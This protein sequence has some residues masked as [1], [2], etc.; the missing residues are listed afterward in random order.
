LANDISDLSGSKPKCRILRITIY[1][2]GRSG[3]LP[4]TESDRDVR[5]GEEQPSKT[6]KRDRRHATC[7]IADETRDFRA[8]RLVT[9][10]H[11]T[12]QPM[13]IREKIGI[14]RCLCQ[15]QSVEQWAYPKLST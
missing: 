3:T 13:K 6:R 1:P 14:Y 2:V 7:V 11:V 8:S 15:D 10:W 9:P 5:R 4:R 12:N